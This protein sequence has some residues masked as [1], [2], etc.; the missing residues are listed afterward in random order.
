M[1]R[2]IDSYKLNVNDIVV[3]VAVTVK[4]EIQFLFTAFQ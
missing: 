2:L 3:D 1:D 4:E